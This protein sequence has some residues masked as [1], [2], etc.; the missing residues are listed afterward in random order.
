MKTEKEYLTIVTIIIA[1]SCLVLTTYSIKF[2]MIFSLL[3]GLIKPIHKRYYILAQ[4]A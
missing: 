1:I 2:S 4:M 3:Y